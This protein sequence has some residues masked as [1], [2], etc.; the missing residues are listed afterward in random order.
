MMI[1]QRQYQSLS[2]YLQQNTWRN[3]GYQINLQSAFEDLE[4]RQKLFNETK[5]TIDTMW[6]N[7][8]KYVE[9]DP[10]TPIG[11]AFG[12]THNDVEPDKNLIEETK[13]VCPLDV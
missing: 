5:N 10:G 4:K 7:I 9:L 1:Q 11:G 8:N 12:N 6:T 13:V 2:N 3:S